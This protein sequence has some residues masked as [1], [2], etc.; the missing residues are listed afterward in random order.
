METVTVAVVGAGIAGNFHCNAVKDVYSA[1]TRLKTVV[2]IDYERALAMRDKWG[3]QLA[4]ADY[5][6]VLQDPEI[7]LV[8]I[9]LP[10]MLHADFSAKA[11]SAGKH[12]VCEKPLTGYFGLPEDI[13]APAD[14]VSKRKIYEALL[15]DMNCVRDA[16]NE[17][18]ANFM[19]AENYVYTPNILKVAEHLCDLEVRVQGFAAECSVNGSTPELTELSRQIGSGSLMR[20]AAYPLS[21]VLFF[22]Q[23]EALAH[24]NSIRVTSVSADIA[25]NYTGN[26]PGYPDGAENFVDISVTFSDG[27]KAAVYSCDKSAYDYTMGRMRNWIK[28]D[29][30]NDIKMESTMTPADNMKTYFFD[31]EGLGDAS[32]N[33]EWLRKAAAKETYYNYVARL[34]EFVKCAS[35]N[36]QSPDGFSL[37]YDNVKIIYAA[38]LSAEEG[39]HIYL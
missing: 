25:P 17:S 22:K 33:I 26:L 11:L 38:C 20:L 8:C 21:G 16:V 18:K 23:S 35:K 12:V 32:S 3:F 34:N 5:E 29:C 39:S 15:R 31:Q 6:S 28:L 30:D 27:S 4:T 24:G 2:D 37:A 36:L 7:D 13:Y 19:Y 9:A 1:K 14:I 10:L